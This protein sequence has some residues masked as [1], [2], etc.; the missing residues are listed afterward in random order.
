[1]ALQGRTTG[2]LFPALATRG[3][4]LGGHARLQEKAIIPGSFNKLLQAYARQIGIK[5][6]VS[7]H[8]LRRSHVHQALKNKASV[9]AV[10]QQGRWKSL[11]MVAEYAAGLQSESDNSSMYLG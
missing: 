2:P 5:E 11:D 1:M 6:G 9:V 10:Q 7:T 8:S 3:S 4:R